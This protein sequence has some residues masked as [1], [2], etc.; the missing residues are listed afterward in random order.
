MDADRL[1]LCK[2]EVDIKELITAIV[3]RF[4]IAAQAKNVNSTKLK[5][6]RR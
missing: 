5:N 4:K 2:T 3:G 1:I 6:G